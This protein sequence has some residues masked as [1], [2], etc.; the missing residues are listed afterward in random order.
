MCSFGETYVCVSYAKKNLE[1]LK[2]KNL[3]ICS[4]QHITGYSTVTSGRYM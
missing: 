4:D 2:K 1:N 3:D